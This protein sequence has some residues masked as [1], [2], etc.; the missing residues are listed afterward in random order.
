MRLYLEMGLCWRTQGKAEHQGLNP[1]WPVSLQKGHHGRVRSVDDTVRGIAAQA[2]ILWGQMACKDRRQ[3]PWCSLLGPVW[4]ELES[5]TDPRNG[6][7][8]RVLPLCPHPPWPP[9]VASAGPVSNKLFGVTFSYGVL[10]NHSLLSDTPR[11]YYTNANLTKSQHWRRQPSE[12]REGDWSRAGAGLPQAGEAR[13]EPPLGA[14]RA[15][16]ALGCPSYRLPNGETTFPRLEPRGLW[17]LVM[18][19]L[20][21]EDR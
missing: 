20:E 5:H 3:P 19:A 14:G 8:P 9:Q 7:C 18:S 6:T 16:R 4:P 11:L 15:L 1:V 2:L 10:L 17:C 21:N 13:E 12:G